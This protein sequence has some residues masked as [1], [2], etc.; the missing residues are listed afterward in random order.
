MAFDALLAGWAF[1]L[2]RVLFG[3]VLSFNGLNHFRQTGEMAGMA[4]SN[5]IPAPTVVVIATGAL[6]VLGGVSLVVGVYPLLGALALVAFFVGTTPWIHDF[7]NVDDTGEKQQQMTHFL[8]YPALLGGAL[9]LFGR[10]RQ[11]GRSRRESVSY[12]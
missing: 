4:E 5:G 2:G 6:L 12:N 8:K 11:S 3:D 9:A 10:P 1:L 7:W